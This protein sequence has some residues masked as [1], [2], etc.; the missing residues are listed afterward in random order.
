MNTPVGL[1]AAPD[2]AKQPH[3]LRN[4]WPHIVD[5]MDMHSQVTDGV[6]TA[7]GVLLPPPTSWSRSPAA[8]SFF[9]NPTL[10]GCFPCD[11]FGAFRPFTPAEVRLLK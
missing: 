3:H 6:G 9:M 4:R 8:K 2:F 1:G 7:L 10:S 11:A 5:V